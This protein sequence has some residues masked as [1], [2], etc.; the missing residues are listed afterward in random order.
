MTD[1][2]FSRKLGH[3]AWS[4]ATELFEDLAKQGITSP[5]SIERAYKKDSNLFW[6]LLR[7]ITAVAELE[8][9]MN[10][11]VDQLVTYSEYYRPWFKRYRVTFT[12]SCSYLRN[13]FNQTFFSRRHKMA[14]HI[15]K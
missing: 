12:S 9:T 14:D 13:I 15:L 2:Y 1:P 7:M 10:G 11:H 5:R 8:R 6:R 3:S 4:H